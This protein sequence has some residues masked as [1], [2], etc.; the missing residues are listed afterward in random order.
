MAKDRFHNIV[1]NAFECFRIPYGTG[2]IFELSRSLEK[3][4]PERLLYLGVIQVKKCPIV[5]ANVAKRNEAIAW[6]PSPCDC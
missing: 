3:V 1:I 5:I 4:E 6:S 2:T